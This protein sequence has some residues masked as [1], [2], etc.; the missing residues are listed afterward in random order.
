MPMEQKIIL[1]GQEITYTIRMSARSRHVRF[2]IYPDGRFVVSAPRMIR[3]S[4]IED[5][6][7]A[8][9]AWI[10][11]KVAEKFAHSK[12]SPPKKVSK[13][14]QR[15]DFLLYKDRARVLIEQKL[16]YFNKFYEFRFNTVMI[17]NQSTRWGSCSRKGNLNFNYKIIFLPAPLVDYIVV[18]ELCHLHELNH[19]AKFWALVGRTLPN[20]RELKKQLQSST[21]AVYRI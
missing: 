17:K 16:E 21:V 6:L 9:V 14:D 7:H 12:K 5:M 13:K 20:W 1:L 11:E 8:R 10:T 3:K 15:D 4:V 2:V 18:H 19:S